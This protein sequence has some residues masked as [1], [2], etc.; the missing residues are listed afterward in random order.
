MFLLSD[1]IHI[2]GLYDITANY[3][4]LISDDNTDL[5]YLGTN[6]YGTRILGSILFEDDEELFLRYIQTLISDE[7][8]KDFLAR[9][10]SLRT[11]LN[12]S[13][14]ISIVD[15]DYNKNIL[16]S[17]QMFL[18]AIPEEFL[19]FNDSFCPDIINDS[20]FDYTFSLKGGL[21]DLHKAEPLTVSDTNAKIYHLLNSATTFLDEIDIKHHI[22]SEVALA[23]SYELNFEIDLQETPNL[24][25]I[26]NTD[27][28]NFI[29]RFFNYLFNIL[30][31]EPI[32]AL[33]ETEI[34]SERFIEIS[35]TLRGI[36]EKRNIPTSKESSTQRTLDLLN[37]AVDSLKDLNYN[38]FNIIEVKNQTIAGDKLPIAFIS[39]NFYEK[40]IDKVFIP[41]SEKKDDIISIDEGNTK[42]SLQVY[43]LNKESGKGKA[44]YDGGKS[45][46]KISFTLLGRDEYHGTDF[47][48]SMD[49]DIKIEVEGIG[50]RV[51]GELKEITFTL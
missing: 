9:K 15:K 34:S 33:K 11:I 2:D 18:K 45:I 51:N 14:I 43:Q 7:Q 20:S 32:N 8:L 38:G 13:N 31:N 44:Y 48:K 50:K 27:I 30:P 23:G 19:P 17:A 46:S 41:E 28:K 37:Y 26:S 29:E 12:S 16:R 39:N 24:F 47:T 5:L 40:V 1:T 25:S 36:Y 10:I 42:Y 4:S 3:N 6:K 35:E 21:A 22:Y 49:E